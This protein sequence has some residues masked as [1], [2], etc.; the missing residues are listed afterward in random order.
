MSKILIAGCGDLG[1]RIANQLTAKGHRVWGLRRNPK[2]LP[3]N[4]IPLVAD[5]CRPE[6]LVSLPQ[7]DA[8]YFAASAQAPSEAAYHDTY[9]RGLA[10]LLAAYGGRPPNRLF[11][12]SSSAVY[13]QNQGEW[14]DEQAPTLPTSFR[15]RLMLQAEAMVN[16]HSIPGTV[17]RLTGIYGPGRNRLIRSVMAGSCPRTPIYTNRIHADDGAGFLVHLLDLP[18]TDSLY[19]ATDSKP[20]L[21]SDVSG[22][23]AR[24][25]QRSGHQP[26]SHGPSQPSPNRNGSKRCS[27]RRML[28]TG[29]LLKYPHF[30][31]G[32]GSLIHSFLE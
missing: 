20:A 6:T 9:V 30:K 32:Y 25:L 21:L 8:I 13:H 14:V 12:C 17:V 26:L 23:I 11:F 15:G 3:G 22:W 5:L 29:Y 18:K 7:V 24:Q 4:I 31:T 28:Q 2:P 16:N 10:N 27:N 1:I 19:L